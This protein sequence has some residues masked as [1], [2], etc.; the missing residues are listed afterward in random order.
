[1]T[2]EVIKQYIESQ[3][4]VSPSEEDGFHIGEP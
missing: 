2:D 4:E 3:G 1:V